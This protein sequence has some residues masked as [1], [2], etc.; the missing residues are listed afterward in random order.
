MEE[1]QLSVLE[2]MIKH[3]FE[4]VKVCHCDGFETHVFGKSNMQIHWRKFK[5]QYKITRDRQVL[6][7]WDKVSNLQ[8]EIIKHVAV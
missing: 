4:K 2:L 8:N 6:K 5:Y 1:I 7:A 3:G